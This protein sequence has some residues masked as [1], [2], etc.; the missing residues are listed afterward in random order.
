MTTVLTELRRLP[1][2]KRFRLTWSDGVSAELPWA[3]VRGYCPCAACQGH[4]SNQ[5]RYHPPRHPVAP[6]TIE[7]VGN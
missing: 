6:S 3:V 2:E 5:V 4:G 7:P 1:E